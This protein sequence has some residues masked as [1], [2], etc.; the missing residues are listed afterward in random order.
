MTSD[1]GKITSLAAWYFAN[2]RQEAAFEQCPDEE[3]LYD[4]LSGMLDPAIQ[5]DV[6]RHVCRCAACTETLLYVSRMKDES[7]APGTVQ[8]P[9]K[10]HRQLFAM[11]PG[12]APTA[13]GPLAAAAAFGERLWQACCAWLSPAPEPDFVYLRGSRHVIS[14]NLVAVEKVFKDILLDI[15]IEK[16]GDGATDIKVRTRLPDSDDPFCG[17]RLDLYNDTRE[18][19]SLVAARGDVLF[20]N[21]AFGDYMLKAWHSGK[22]IGE[23]QLTIKE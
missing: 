19:A 2:R 15:E 9:A 3:T 7:P 5:E 4:Y 23:V 12:K 14:K 22:Q 1:D 18:I 20:E 17:V 16:T 6:E 21:I 8:V 13:P 11:A 10:L